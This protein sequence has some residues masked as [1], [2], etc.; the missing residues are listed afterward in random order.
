MCFSV[1]PVLSFVPFLNVR[2][3]IPLTLTAF[4]L[5][6][7]LDYLGLSFTQSV[8]Y[9]RGGKMEAGGR[10]GERKSGRF[11]FAF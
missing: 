7:N 10:Y 1:L 4:L 8:P 11:A 3:G 2:E 9:D 6:W 5:C